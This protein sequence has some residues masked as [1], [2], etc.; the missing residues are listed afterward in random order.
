MN[1]IIIIN[2]PPIEEYDEII[3]TVKDNLDLTEVNF[4]KKKKVIDYHEDPNK[5]LDYQ[6]MQIKENYWRINYGGGCIYRFFPLTEK[7]LE[8]FDNFLH[9]YNKKINCIID[10]EM[11]Q[12]VIKKKLTKVKHDSIVDL[13]YNE[14]TKMKGIMKKKYPKLYYQINGDDFEENVCYRIIHVLQSCTNLYHYSHMIEPI[15]NK[16]DN[17]NIY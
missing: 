5:A 12:D 16:T 9:K 15:V 17:Y 7:Q 6:N 14:M 3:N 10:I 1:N 13:Y 2:H 11:D 4:I 8:W